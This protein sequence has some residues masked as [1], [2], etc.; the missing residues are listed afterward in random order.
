MCHQSSHHCPCSSAGHHTRGV[1]GQAQHYRP[2]QLTPPLSLL[3]IVCDMWR[4]IMS[5]V[6]GVSWPHARMAPPGSHHHPAPSRDNFLPIW[7]SNHPLRPQ[8]RWDGN[9]IWP[10]CWLDI[11]LASLFRLCPG[12]GSLLRSQSELASETSHLT[13]SRLNSPSGWGRAILNK[14]NGLRLCDDAR[15]GHVVRHGNGG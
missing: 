10:Q 11:M 4:V 8:S 1:T 15:A 2:G 14:S 3:Y 12:S 7:Y 9:L 13:P 6:P 5:H